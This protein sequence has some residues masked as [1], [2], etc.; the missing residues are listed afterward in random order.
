MTGRDLASSYCQDCC[1]PIQLD[2]RRL[3]PPKERRLL[4]DVERRPLPKLP[5]LRSIRLE[6][7]RSDWRRLLEPNPEPVERLP[8]KPGLLR[9][10]LD[11]GDLKAP[12]VRSRA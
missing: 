2:Q 5:E 9:A 10:A 8:D 7:D 4:P 6:R 1:Y 11:P 3:L 12:V